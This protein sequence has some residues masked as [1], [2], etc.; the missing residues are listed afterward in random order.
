M[1]TRKD[2]LS[3]MVKKAKPVGIKP[4]VNPPASLSSTGGVKPFNTL[5][6]QPGIRPPVVA[7]KRTNLPIQTQY[8]KKLSVTPSAPQKIMPSNKESMPAMKF[9]SL[10]TRSRLSNKPTIGAIN[11]PI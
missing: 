1:D 10:A 9:P 3:T 7:D 4:F 11:R 8:S 2:I 6:D 5:A